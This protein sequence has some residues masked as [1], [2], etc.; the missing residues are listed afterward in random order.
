MEIRVE[1]TSIERLVDTVA[2]TINE[3][4]KN[5]TI[6]DVNMYK[7][8]YNKALDDLMAKLDCDKYLLNDWQRD[9]IRDKVKE[10]KEESN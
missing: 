6:D 2:N 8:G 10:I 7:L 5:V 1:P 9:A 4:F 3:S